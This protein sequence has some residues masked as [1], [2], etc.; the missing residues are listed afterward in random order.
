MKTLKYVSDVYFKCH[1]ITRHGQKYDQYKG[2]NMFDTFI[3]I[4]T[5]HM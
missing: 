3:N 5:N 2:T 4:K 1:I